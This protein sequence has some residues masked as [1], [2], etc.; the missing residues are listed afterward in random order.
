MPYFDGVNGYL[1]IRPEVELAH[2]AGVG[3]PTVVHHGASHGY[4]LPIYADNDEEIYMHDHIP[5]RWD[6]ASDIVVTAK[7]YLGA[8]EDV[9]DSFRLQLSWSNKAMTSGVVPSTTTDIN[10]ETTLTE[11]RNAQYSAYK[12]NFT[13]DWNLLTPNI[14]IDD[15]LAMRLRR[16]AAVGTDI[17]G[18]FVIVDIVM[19]YRT[20]KYYRAMI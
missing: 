6:S 8:A 17:D 1:V 16:I 4:S 18:E 7:G 15:Y 20:N 2:I 13:I 11:G 9:G 10:V 3:K 14:A 19:T 5:G 12:I